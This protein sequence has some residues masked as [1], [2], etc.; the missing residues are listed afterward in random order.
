MLLAEKIPWNLEQSSH[1]MEIRKW[2]FP[3]S[4]FDG[5]YTQGPNVTANVIIIVQL[6]LTCNN[7]ENKVRINEY[8][9]LNCNIHSHK[10]T[11]PPTTVY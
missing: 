1:G 3:I 5:S 10:E 11:L 2:W 4:Q 7:L 9:T 6:S 8:A